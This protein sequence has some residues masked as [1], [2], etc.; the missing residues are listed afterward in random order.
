MTFAARKAVSHK[1]G[2]RGKCYL[3]LRSFDFDTVQQGLHFRIGHE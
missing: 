3:L 2:L 1:R